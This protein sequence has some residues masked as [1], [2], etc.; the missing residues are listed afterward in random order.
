[1]KTTNLLRF[2]LASLLALAAGR[3]FAANVEIQFSHPENFTDVKESYSDSANE[4]G[5]ANYLPQIK[6]LMVRQAGAL[7][8]A[9]QKLTVTFTD[10]DLAGDFEPWLGAQF[11]DI[12]IVKAIYLPRL[13]FNFTLTDADGKVLKEGERRL[14]DLGFQ[15]RI[16]RAFASDPLR[17]EKDML[18]D[19]VRQELR[20]ARS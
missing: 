4:R 7:L 15:T 18:T 5:G 16:T 1:M 11:D 10:I 6:A 8:S 13:T 19:W 2:L 3:A 9:G 20:S 17:Y 14:V 12:R